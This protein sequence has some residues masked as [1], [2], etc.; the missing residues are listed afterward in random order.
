MNVLDARREFFAHLLAAQV[1]A[2]DGGR[3]EAAF[4]STPREKFLGPG[5]WRAF[6]ASGYIAIPAEHPELVYQDITVALDAD[7]HINN[8]QPSLHALCLAALT[9]QASD[10]VLHIGAGTGYYTAILAQLAP[11]GTVT[12][13]ELDPELARRAAE[14][15]AEYPNTRLEGRSGA[16]G[17]LPQSDVIYVNA[18]ATRP[19][20][21]W[22][23]ALRPGGRLVFPLTGGHGTGAMLLVTRGPDDAPWPA[24]MLLP[25]AFIDCEG[26]RD[27]E[28]EKRLNAAFERG[29]WRSVRTLHRGT[30]PAADA[31]VVGNGW[32]LG[33]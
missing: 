10:R 20:E 28:E 24:H 14:N 13:L 26:A 23:R 33:R 5:P 1:Q 32:R 11:Q 8:G 27:P 22:L 12:G 18:G 31:W 9:V 3:L 29:Q 19:L 2:G 16:E 15:L 4:R 21:A 7:R 30:E 25:V 17:E 6:T